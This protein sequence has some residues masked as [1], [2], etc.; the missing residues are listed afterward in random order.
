MDAVC[1]P[2]SSALARERAFGVNCRRRSRIVL[3]RGNRACRFAAIGGAS[4]LARTSSRRVRPRHSLAERLRATGASAHGCGGG[5]IC[6]GGT[7]FIRSGNRVAGRPRSGRRRR[8]RNHQRRS[9]GVARTGSRSGRL[10][11]RSCTRVYRRCIC[12][13]TRRHHP[14]ATDRTGLSTARR[15]SARVKFRFGETIALFAAFAILIA[16]AV[17]QHPRGN[18]SVYSTYDGGPDGYRA[19]Y[20]VLTR[21]R[22]PVARLETQLALVSQAG[23]V[24]ITE[25]SRE[26]LAGAPYGSLDSSDVEQLKD[27]A[28]HGRVLVFAERGSTLAR[29]L[30]K[31][32]IRFDPARYTNAALARNPAAALAVYG[33]VAGRGTVLFD[34]RLHGYVQDRSFWA[35]LPQTVHAAVWIAAAILVLMLIDANVRILPPD[36]LEL[37]QERDSSSYIRSMATMLRRG[38]AGR[39]AIA[40]FAEDAARA[41]PRTH[42]AETQSKL[43]DLQQLAQRRNPGDAAVLHAARLYAWIR[44]EG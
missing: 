9:P 19:L 20:G 30:G 43:Q 12:R 39:A 2:L 24:A 13:E 44:K 21:E 29:T 11:C 42:H 17:L 27:F 33:A 32:A 37:P 5:K 23:V 8:K 18:V 40:R 3:C 6:G 15:A 25:T 1:A 28:K 4:T 7:V 22:I 26:R 38:R 34:E 31:M 41:H 16:V 14:L 10:V 36:T 35:A